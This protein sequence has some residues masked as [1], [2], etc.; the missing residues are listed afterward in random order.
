MKNIL[1]VADGVTAKSFLLRLQATNA[2]KS[3]YYVVYYDDSVL[4]SE[5]SDKF[6]YYKFDPTSLSKISTVLKSVDFYQAM[7]ILSNKQ[8][9]L[10]TVE[11]I[12][13]IAPKLN[14]TILDRWGLE[15]GSQ[16]ITVVDVDE[17]LVNRFMNHIPN[18]PVYAKEVGLGIGDVIDMTIPFSSS[19][20]YKHIGSITQNRWKIAAVYRKKRLI[21]PTDSMMLLPNDSVLAVG[22]PAV[23][24]GVYRSVNREFGQFPQPFGENIYTIIDML[25]F[26]EKE[27]ELLINDSMILHS[28]LNNKNLIFKVINPS[29]TK[30]FDKLKSYSSDTMMVEIDYINRTFEDSLKNDIKNHEVGLVLTN[31]RVFKEYQELFYEIKI[32]IFK[33]ANSGFSNMKESIVLSS[34]S[35]KVETISSSLFDISSQLE[36]DIAWFELNNDEEENEKVL[37]HFDSLSKLFERKINIKK[38][39]KN[40]IIELKKNNSYL[41]FIL[42]EEEIIQMSFYQKTFSTK[43]DDHF[44]KLSQNY[45]IFIP[46]L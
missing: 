39:N 10:A 12:T 19:Y 16:N 22:S 7:L 44:S 33:I 17:H 18:I 31:N 21:L 26:S 27:I 25:K 45:Q 46:V 8:D 38:S 11:N 20:A 9:L 35:T 30:C 15:L 24:Q 6:F 2:Q 42:F 43:F 13:V 4:P 3:R 34:S 28:R 37:E 29:L 40:P 14:I 41:Q 1:I 23:L 32:P 36:L 5:K